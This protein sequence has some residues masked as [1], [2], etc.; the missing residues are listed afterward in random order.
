MTTFIVIFLLALSLTLVGTNW[1]RRLALWL[2]FVDVP[3]QR[4]LHAEPIPLMGGVAIFG[5]AIVAILPFLSVLPRPVIAVWLSSAIVA[6]TGLVDDRLGL[7]A[8]VKL[9]GQ[10]IGF[11]VLAAFD[12]RVK[13]PLP[14]ILDYV[15]TF[16]WLAGIS[17]AVNFLDNMD[18]LSAGIS[19]VSA[20]F[21]MLLGLQ[22]G[23]FLVAAVAA[24]IL[25]ACVGFLRYNFK[26]AR[27]FMGDAGA[28]FLGFLLAVLG[29]R[30]RF[31]ENVNFV[32]WMVPVFILGLPIFDTTLVVISR[33]RRGLS[34]LTA[35][36]DHISH[37][38]V[39]MG[40]SQREAVLILY[41][42]AGMFGMAGLFITEAS[43][44]EGYTIGGTAVLVAAFA[45]WRLER[46]VE[47]PLS[48]K[49]EVHTSENEQA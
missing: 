37:R 6:L 48:A 13:L 25:G 19:A 4:K 40:F 10:F 1:A 11:L 44:V 16:L 36:K 18:G 23:Q 32:T 30:L 9:L 12:I 24:A 22:N 7:P 47:Q 8:W 21:I 5:G 17:N 3:A 42:V 27:I 2:G 45:I 20:A 33:L 35:G 46:W 26:P 38:L 49:R 41:L 29:L 15:I 34:P 28:L 14:D 31:P 43:V 39:A